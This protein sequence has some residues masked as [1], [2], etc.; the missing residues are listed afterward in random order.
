[1]FPP[2][3]DADNVN[4]QLYPT[5]SKPMKMVPIEVPRVSGENFSV[6]DPRK[7]TSILKMSGPRRRRGS[8]K[9][10]LSGRP[11]EANFNPE[12]KWTR[13][14]TWVSEKISVW[15]TRGSQLQS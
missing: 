5:L 10:F 3:Q 7:P 14:K 15:K 9:R 11:E 6:R 2:I 4:Q 12:N 8:Q 13:K 1:M